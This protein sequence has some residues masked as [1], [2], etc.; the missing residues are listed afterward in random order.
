MVIASIQEG[1][2]GCVLG[3]RLVSA[4]R[5]LLAMQWTFNLVHIYREANHCVDALADK[6]CRMKEDMI[7]ISHFS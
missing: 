3:V 6:A 4:I 7:I 1:K 2:Q 5:H